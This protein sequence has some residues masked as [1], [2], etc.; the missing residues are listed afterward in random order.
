MRE[1]KG[2]EPGPELSRG[3]HGGGGGCAVAAA[4][5]TGVEMCS[6]AFWH[7]KLLGKSTFSK[8]DSLEDDIKRR[9]A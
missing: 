8:G 6:G 5:G 9:I 1:R 7:I 3:S 4:H 2:E